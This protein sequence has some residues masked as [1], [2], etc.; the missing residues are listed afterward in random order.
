MKEIKITIFIQSVV[1]I[2]GLFIWK[3]INDP[4]LMATISWADIIASSVFV[5][6]LSWL[7]IPTIKDDSAGRDE[8]RD[9]VALRLGKFCNRTTRSLKRRFIPTRPD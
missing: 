9:G 7:L 6:L 2:G 8:S 4:W 5:L 3:T 1:L